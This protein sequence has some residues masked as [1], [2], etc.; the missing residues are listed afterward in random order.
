MKMEQIFEYMNCAAIANKFH[1]VKEVLTSIKTSQVAQLDTLLADKE[2]SKLLSAFQHTNVQKLIFTDFNYIER[3]QKF[4][5]T[6][7]DVDCSDLNILLSILSDSNKSIDDFSDELLYEGI[8]SYA[9]THDILTSFVYLYYNKTH[10]T[11]NSSIRNNIHTCLQLPES[12]Y[13]CYNRFK[14]CC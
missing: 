3:L 1:I 8:Q 13:C 6:Y 10:Q 5:R 4:L 7:E 14:H 11:S 2:D 9:D 12:Y